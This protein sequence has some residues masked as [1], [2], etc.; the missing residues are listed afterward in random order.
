MAHLQTGSAVGDYKLT[1]LVGTGGMAEV[2]RA[3]DTRSGQDVAVKVFGPSTI[4]ANDLARFYQ[5]VRVQRELSHP[6]IVA[7]RDLVTVSG[8]PC[9]VMEFVDGETL[10]QRI[11]RLGRLPAVESL[12]YLRDLAAAVAYAH[13]HGVVHRDIKPSNIRVTPA[14]VVKLLDFG[15]AK[16]RHAQALTKAGHVIGTPRYLSPEQLLGEQA[17]DASD[18]WA[19]GVVVYE[20]VTGRA[21]FDGVTPA[22]LWKAIEGG[23]PLSPSKVVNDESD[24]MRTVEAIVRRCLV[25]EPKRRRSARQISEKAARGPVCTGAMAFVKPGLSLVGLRGRVVLDAVGRSWKGL[26][27]ASATLLLLALIWATTPADGGGKTGVRAEHRIDVSLG[28]ATVYV[29]GRELGH[30]PVTY[31]GTA[32]EVIDIEVRLDGY[33]TRRERIEVRPNGTTTLTLDAQRRTSASQGKLP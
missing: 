18:V 4:E 14:G 13:E 28:S 22:E 11:T 6:N 25:R 1:A 2:Y 7:Y 9:M 32:G 3:T 5:E 15:I 29:N 21:P 20:M 8:R 27:L 23:W 17:T 12:Q 31:V 26:A 24:A 10:A 16:P 33:E 30:T 19:L